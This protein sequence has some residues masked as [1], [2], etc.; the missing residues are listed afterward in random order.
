MIYLNAGALMIMSVR[1]KRRKT[2]Y[3]KQEI[4]TIRL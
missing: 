4:F 1:G 2:Q 3:K